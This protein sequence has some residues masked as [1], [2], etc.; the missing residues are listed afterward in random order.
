MNRAAKTETWRGLVDRPEVDMDPRRARFK[1]SEAVVL[2][3]GTALAQRY[4]EQDLDAAGRELY[5][6]PSL[7]W[8]EPP[9]YLG[10]CFNARHRPTLAELRVSLVI[11]VA[12][13]EETAPEGDGLYVV[14]CP[15]PGASISCS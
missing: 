7:M 9:I 12:A 6:A 11:C 13:E 8:D 5:G 2:R 4:S 1:R 3:V 10:S 14:R 15:L